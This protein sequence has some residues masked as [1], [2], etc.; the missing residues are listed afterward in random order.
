MTRAS[1]AQLFSL[2]LFVVYAAAD[3]DVF[4]ASASCCTH[5]HANNKI[6]KK[7]LKT[8]IYIKN[9]NKNKNKKRNDNLTTIT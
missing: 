2:L 6:L 8:N 4:D 9:N 1:D 5:G 3:D 7:L